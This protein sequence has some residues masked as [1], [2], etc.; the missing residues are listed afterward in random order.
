MTRAAGSGSGRGGVAARPDLDH[1]DGHQHQD[2]DHDRVVGGILRDDQADADDD[3][4]ER[5]GRGHGG[6]GVSQAG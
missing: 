6:Q 5:S 2:H 1:V 3:P 4:V